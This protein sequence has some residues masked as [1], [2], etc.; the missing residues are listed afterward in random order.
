[1]PLHDP[2]SMLPSGHPSDSLQR[3]LHPPTLFM[4]SVPRYRSTTAPSAHRSRP[5]SPRRR[6]VTDIDHRYVGEGKMSAFSS[7]EQLSSF[8]SDLSRRPSSRDT[9]SSGI[10]Q[11][12]EVRSDGLAKSLLTKSSRL[13]LRRKSGKLGLPSSRTLEWLEDT[14]DVTTKHVQ[15]LSK[16]RKSKHSRIESNDYGNSSVHP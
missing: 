4:D 7:T 3:L 2:V 14:E 6:A 9:R 13:L 5:Q 16:R 11:W 15:E 1:M 12:E 8:S 10:S